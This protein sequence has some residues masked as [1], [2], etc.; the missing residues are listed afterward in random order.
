MPV[1]FLTPTQREQYGRY[2][3]E[4]SDEDLARFFYRDDGMRELILMRRGDHNRLGFALQLTTVRYLGTCLDRPVDDVPPRVR[5]TVAA[6][7]EITDITGLGEYQNTRQRRRHVAEIRERYGYRELSDP[8][9]GFRLT[10]WLCALCWT[11]TERPGVLFERATAWMLTH[12]VL[13]PGVT[14]L[15]RFVAQVRARMEVRLWRLLARGVTDD[16]RK[17]LEA[18]L[19]VAEGS[20]QSWLD[21]LRKGPVHVSGPALVQALQRVETIRELGISLPAA[22]HIP[23]SRLAALARFA[24]AVKVTVLQPAAPGASA[25]GAG[26]FRTQHGSQRPG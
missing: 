10:R 21:K 3:R 24:G 19:T 20:R 13:L 17:K 8:T 26:R 22:A 6:Q 11:G 12:K 16:Q 23:R 2:P 9:V 4:L 15:E 1:S 25:R 18:L 5:V 7:L 14:T